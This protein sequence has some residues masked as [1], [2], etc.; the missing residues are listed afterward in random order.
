L[1]V[2]YSPYVFYLPHYVGLDGNGN[3]LY[4]SSGSKTINAGNATLHYTDP[5]PKF[6]YGINNTFTYKKWSLNFFLRGVSGEK[7]FNNNSLELAN[8]NRLPGNNVTQDALTNG[9][10]NASTPSDYYLQKASFLRLDNATLSYTF[11]NVLKGVED[12]QVYISGNNLF[13]ITPYKGLDPEI[14]NAQINGS[15]QAYIDANYAGDGIYP[16][17]RSFSFGVNVSF[18]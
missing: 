6:N 10:K 12:L 4:D 7:V 18:K 16:K 15:N 1:K 9:I 8:I 17:T 13:V 5:A 3:Q 11:G 2:G 14:R